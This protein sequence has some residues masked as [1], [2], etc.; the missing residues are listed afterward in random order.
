M[1]Q[2]MRILKLL[3]WAAA[4]VAALAAAGVATLAVQARTVG[5]PSGLGVTNGRLAACPDSP[6]C[7]STQADPLDLSHYMQP[8]PL[9][10]PAA[11][12][13]QRLREVLAGQAR[14]ELL[15]DEPNYIHTVFRTAGFGF[16]D[17]VE[18]YIDESAGLIHFRSAAR[19]GRGDLG[20]NR[21]RMEQVRAELMAALA[22]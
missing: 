12:A 2:T 22:R 4:G 17:D 18:F 19:L 1:E 3:G 9:N 6:N 11:E 7:V 16:P 20:V 13:Q 5:V 10:L 15:R 8:L 21:A 14:V